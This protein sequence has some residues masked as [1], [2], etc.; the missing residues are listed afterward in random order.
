MAQQL[1]N[2]TRMHEDPGLIPGLAQWVKDPVLPLSCS[3][4]HRQSSDL[5]LLW[6]WHRPAAA[7][8]IPPLTWELPYAVT[9]AL[10]KK[11]KKKVDVFIA[12][13][14]YFLCILG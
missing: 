13:R 14:V 4:G 5:A 7:T 6:L 1:M 3:V 11:K 2:P 9:T 10:K 12:G 8:S